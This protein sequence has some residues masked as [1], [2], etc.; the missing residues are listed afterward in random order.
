MG[1]D[2]GNADT[3]NKRIAWPDPVLPVANEA[4]MIGWCF[5]IICL[6]YW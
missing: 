2:V 5:R 3:R 1:F 4:S 6:F